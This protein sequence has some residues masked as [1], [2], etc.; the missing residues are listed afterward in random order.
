MNL[1]GG[2]LEVTQISDIGTGGVIDITFGHLIMPGDQRAVV[3]PHISSS[4]IVA[5]GGTEPVQMDYDN[6][7]PGMTTVYAVGGLQEAISA[8]PAGS[9]IYVPA[10]IYNEGQ[11]DVNK[12]LTLKAVEGPDST[13]INVTGNGLCVVSDDVTI[14]G[15]TLQNEGAPVTYLVRV[16]RST[17]NMGYAIECCTILDCVLRSGDRADGITVYGDTNE[18]ELFS[19]RISECVNGMVVYDNALNVSIIDNDFHNNLYGVR[20]LGSEQQ[21]RILSNGIYWN[22]NYGLLN[23]GSETVDAKNNFWGKD[24]GPYHSILNPMGQGNPVSNRVDFVPYFEGCS[25]DRWHICPD[26]DVNRD[27]RVDFLDI[28]LLADRWLDCNG[29]E[30]N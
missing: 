4:K 19:N 17:D 2:T 18:I 1:T 3:S 6:V 16:G 8:A 11:F 24:S 12:P 13:L 21:L 29:P 27:C 5:F 26:G 30:C 7:N 14:D 22:E 28:S 20:V 9:T 25:D 15:F 10:G 23:S